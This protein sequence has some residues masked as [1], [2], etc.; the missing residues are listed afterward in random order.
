MRIGKLCDS[1]AEAEVSF[2]RADIKTAASKSQAKQL[3]SSNWY[4]WWNLPFGLRKL[5]SL[6]K[7]LKCFPIPKTIIINWRF[8]CMKSKWA[9]YSPYFIFLKTFSIREQSF[10]DECSRSEYEI[11]YVIMV[12]RTSRLFTIKPKRNTIYCNTNNILI[13][14]WMVKMLWADWDAG[15]HVVHL[16]NFMPLKQRTT[17][18]V[19]HR[20]ITDCRW[21][22]FDTTSATQR[23][24]TGNMAY[25]L[26]ANADVLQCLPPCLRMKTA[27]YS[28]YILKFNSILYI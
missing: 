20:V 3:R 2:C 8:F 18:P 12:K 21:R 28:L 24:I 19:S 7:K 5:I 11:F 27:W 1:C 4:D 14:H 15:T 13:E 10:E 22:W 25:R 9:K 16:I 6:L 23:S 17:S 26:L